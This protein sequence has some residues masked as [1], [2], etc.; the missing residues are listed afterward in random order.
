[1]NNNFAQVKKDSTVVIRKDN[2]QKGIDS[3]LVANKTEKI[4]SLKNILKQKKDLLLKKEIKKDTI[5]FLRFGDISTKF[6]KK[7]INLEQGEIISNVLKVIN[8]GTKRL[9]F[10]T[11]AL[12]PAG[13]I[14]IDDKDK[15]YSVRA[16]DTVI[17]P[18]VLSP[19]K[20]I[21]G[22]TEIIINTFIID[23]DNIQLANNF[24]SLKTRKKISWEIDLS[25]IKD[26]YFKNEETSKRFDFNVKNTGNYKQDLFVNYSI[27]KK[28]LFLSDTLGKVIKNPNKTFTLEA[29]E[30][31]SFKF[32]V[33]VKDLNQRNKRRISL[34]AYT[35]NKNITK[36]THTLVVN[37]SEPKS[38]ENQLNKRTKVNFI[39][40]PNEIE[41]NQ[42]GYPYI[43]V[44]VDISA[45]NILDDRSFLSLNL[46]GFKQISDT[47]SL[48]YSTQ[49]NYSNSFFTNSV[50]ANAPWY[51]GY[52]DDKKTVEVG[53]VSGNLLGVASAGKGVKGSYRLN[54]KHQVG[55]FYVN[56]T[57][58]FDSNSSI[59][60]GGWHRFKPNN[61]INIT[62]RF[63][64][65]KNNISNR[66][67]NVVSLHPSI[68]FNQKHNLNLVTA[69]TN[70]D[71]EIKPTG[72]VSSGYLFGGS[73]SSLFLN[74]KLRV[75]VSLN[76]NDKNYSFGNFERY[77]LNQRYFYSITKKWTANFSSNYQGLNNYGTNSTDVLFK[78]ELFYNNLVFTTKSPSGSYQ[79]G[80]YFEYRNLPISS[81]FAK[82]ITFRYS[83]FNFFNN[84]VTSLF[85]KAGY[86]KPSN[87]PIEEK[88]YFS[89]ETT[90]LLRYQTWS[91]TA[92][93]NLGA[94]SS[95]TSQANSNTVITPQSV[96]ISAQNQYLFKNRKLAIE[97]NLIYS[98]NNVFQNHTL[99]VFPVAYYFTE[100]GFRFGF[101]ANYT[102]TS[103]DF[104]SVFDPIDAL[105]NPEIANLGPSTTSNFNINFSL[106]KEF[107]IPIPFSKKTAASTEFISFLDINGNGIKDQ[108]ESTIQNVVIKLNKNEV[109][110]N[111]NGQAKIKNLSTKKYKL[112]TFSL[113]KLNGWFPNVK[114]SIFI[115][116][117]AI[118]H[119]PFVRG[120]KVYGDVILDRQKIAVADNQNIDLSRIKV[121]ASKDDKSYSSLT[122]RDGRFEFYLP[123]GNYTITMDEQI[124]NERFRITRN[125]IPLTLKNS[126]DGVYVS[127]Y[128]IEKRRKV[129][130]KDFSKKKKNK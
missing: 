115:N 73:Y 94:F 82:G 75:N 42:F 70:K 13:W 123:Y 130:F 47:A 8:H 36:K 109:L 129:I 112:E 107:G 108:N 3:T 57:G 1:M 62:T 71:Q 30:F 56:A 113:E 61:D 26:I 49:L 72:F 88:E 104:S 80:V 41:S 60:Y 52:F 2:V 35:P 116:N 48:L 66:S 65:N 7:I 16:K 38:S 125:N 17:V 96:R 23:N 89:F 122:N 105:I 15:K 103:S 40:L 46:R 64:R 6:T 98:Y 97:S 27:P 95:L 28:D 84:F 79:P 92:R 63:G 10:T 121:S 101:S 86:T 12:Y 45:Q 102:Y 43:P 24:F 53:Q 83:K 85:I 44:T 120:V 25:N 50:F 126:Q 31:K 74:R 114:D 33:G 110:T 4:D 69:Y 77:I 117:D 19:T 91:L 93:Y 21:N 5:P 99:G 11:D 78:Q 127:F 54:E 20:L 37:S 9:E 29:K 118:V 67:I 32:L 111:F 59:T 51:V 39:K 55:A 90:S 34:N 128:I 81:F 18:I 119:I 106:R 58:F 14:R 100:T 76:Y 68:R 22:N 124:L 87:T